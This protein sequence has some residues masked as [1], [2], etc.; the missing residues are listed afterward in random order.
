MLKIDG[1][2]VR[3]V[4]KDARAESMVRAIAQLARSMS[5]T[6]VAEYVETPEIGERV[7]ALGVDYGQ[8]FAIGRP[9]SFADLLTELPLPD[10]ADEETTQ[11]SQ[12][13]PAE[14]VAEAAQATRTDETDQTIEEPLP[15]T[16]YA[17]AGQ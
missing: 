6:T 13:I 1:S 2:F 9:I 5:I 3:D 16:W 7:A 12:I 4:L 8:G 11:N 14:P 17:G 10:A 15:V